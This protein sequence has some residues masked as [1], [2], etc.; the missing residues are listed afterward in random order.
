MLACAIL[1]FTLCTSNLTV[2]FP[3]VAKPLQRFVTASNARL[4]ENPVQH[5]V[6]HP[7]PYLAEH[8]VTP[9]LFAASL[10]TSPP[11]KEGGIANVHLNAA[12]LKAVR[13]SEV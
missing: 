6:N 9:N 11:H 8:E 10:E 5:I 2:N 7:L 1:V 3:F 4:F 12:L 13:Q